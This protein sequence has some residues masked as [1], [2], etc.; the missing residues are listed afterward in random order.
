MKHTE[1]ITVKNRYKLKG[2]YLVG[3]TTVIGTLNRGPEVGDVVSNP[4]T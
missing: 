4:Q 1:P 2:I 3:M